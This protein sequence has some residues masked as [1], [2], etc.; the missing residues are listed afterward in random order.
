M[1][2]DYGE[3]STTSGECAEEET[4]VNVTVKRVKNAT[5]VGVLYLCTKWETKE[6]RA[7]T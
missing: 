3:E 7:E 5:R 2:K 1:R 4:D 6:A